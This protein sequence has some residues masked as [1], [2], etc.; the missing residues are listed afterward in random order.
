MNDWHDE[1]QRRL[2]GLRVRPEREAEILDEL[3]QHLDDEVRG[4]IS[5]GMA[6][7]AARAAALAELDAPGELSRRLSE[8]ETRAPLVLPP[9]GAPARGRWLRALVN[10]IR[11]SLRALRHSPNFTIVVIVTLALTIG[12][13]TAILSVGNW[14]VWRPIPGVVHPDQLAEGQSGQWNDKGDV[15]VA[16]IS[17]ANL[18]DIRAGAKTFTGLAGIQEGTSHLSGDSMPPAD[19]GVSWVT[20]GAFEML[21]VRLVAGRPFLQDEDREPAGE[22]VIVVRESVAVRAF[23]S[24]EAA[25][26]QRL[27]LNGRPMTIVGVAAPE[28]R[29]ITA[30]S[31][32]DVWYPGSTYGYVNHFSDNSRLVARGGG[33]FNSFVIR[34]APGSTAEAAQS[35]LNTLLPAL[36]DR[37]PTDNDKFKTVRAKL[38]PGLGT[39]TRERYASIVSTLLAIG[40]ALLLLGCAN[41]AN[42]LMLRA[43]RTERDRAI[44]LALGATRARLV[45][46]QL[47]ESAVLA[48]SG[49]V[50]G[51]LLALWLIQ[52]IV[53]LLFPGMPDGLEFGPPLDWRVLAM[54]M[55][56]S[57]ACG[58]LAGFIPALVGRST[59]PNT[60]IASGSSRTTPVMRWLRGG[61]AGA[62]LA[63]SLA[64]VTGSLLLVTTLRHLHAVD[65]GFEPAGTS[66]HVM[67]PSRQGYSREQ[68][69]AY[70]DDLAQRLQGRGG[71]DAVA[72][73]GQAPFSSSFRV[74]LQDPTGKAPLQVYSNNI[75][76]QYFDV[77]RVPIVH[78]RGFT[79]AETRLPSNADYPVVVDQ[80]LAKRLFGDADPIGQTVVIPAT[81]AN[82]AIHAPVIGVA[83]DVHW[84]NVTGEQ[85]LLMYQPLPALRGASIVLVRSR[86][87]MRDVAAAVASVAKEIDATLP[88]RFSQPITALID[89][90]LSQQR[91]FS[92]ML[93]LL[94]WLALALAAVG[95]YGLLA[96]SV[97]ERTREF[98]VRMALGSGRARIFALVLRQASWIAVIGGA[99][100]LGLAAWGT[101]LIEAQLFGVTRLDPLIYGLAAGVLVAVVFVASLWPARTATRIE[102]VEALRTE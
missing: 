102:P 89:R 20:A 2:S 7:D 13:T 69:A 97:S 46:L 61:L 34:I 26:G 52:I 98:G 22:P 48:V 67:D 79:E 101:R 51:V 21:G 12:P 30:T 65:L 60:V 41:V 87:P 11:F 14:L 82:P 19:T 58:L 91:V 36:A 9:P 57:V 16:S 8:I 28:F 96:Q 17:N 62:Q 70:F 100:G 54:T 31:R 76:A 85:P 27:S 90:K 68:T 50:A 1:L 93:S 88:V 86:M 53:A 84:N 55:A 4:L 6:P 32:V 47:T 49:A 92:W 75:S 71:F 40:G 73:A 10:D 59:A 42:M 94:G 74:R 63:L 23:G 15:I 83:G 72:L 29:G 33:L 18:L 35:E 56:V 43:V 45:A 81:A 25:I 5:G 66:W 3:S 99:C 95:L 39:A 80:R 37:Y 24:A 77:F 64:L 44:R 38:T 78:G